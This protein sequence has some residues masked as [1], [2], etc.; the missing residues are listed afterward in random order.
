MATIH[1][2]HPEDGG[3]M[4]LRNVGIL[5]QHHT[6]SQP[7]RPLL[8]T[9]PPWKPQNS[10]QEPL[11][12][13][14]SYNSPSSLWRWTQHG[15]PKRWYPTTTLDGVTTQKTSTWFNVNSVEFVTSDKHILNE[16]KL[17]LHFSNSIFCA[18]DVISAWLGRQSNVRGNREEVRLVLKKD[19]F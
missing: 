8:K 9:S 17:H 11:W 3:S 4:H 1:T 12:E 15:P 19:T 14:Y 16:P 10:Q 2:L 7:R 18:P 5:P 13:G 6:A